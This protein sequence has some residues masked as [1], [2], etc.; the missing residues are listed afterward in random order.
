MIRLFI[1]ILLGLMLGN[2][3]AH[4]A[5]YKIKKRCY[6]SNAGDSREEVCK[7]TGEK[8]DLI[9]H[10]RPEDVGKKGAFYV[11]AQTENDDIAF[12]TPAGWNEGLSPYDY[13]QTST[14]LPSSIALRIHY[15][16]SGP[17]IA[18]RNST[19]R[20]DESFCSLVKSHGI[21]AVKLWVAYGAVQAEAEEFIANYKSIALEET[22]ADH[23]RIVHAYQDGQKNEKYEKVVFIH[24]GK[25]S[26]TA[27]WPEDAPAVES[28][29]DSGRDMYFLANQPW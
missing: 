7:L 11:G 1:G 27:K 19:A 13:Y 10:V 23:F 8:L 6:M 25:G 4:D 21:E 15:W 22:P 28:F 3:T 12:L 14:S 24:C 5:Q 26:G 17:E 18:G 20:G 16:D 29:I 2:A 9:V